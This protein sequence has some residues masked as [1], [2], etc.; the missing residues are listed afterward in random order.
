[1]KIKNISKIDL[2]EPIPVYDVI[3][4]YPYNN[5][6]IKCNNGY[7]VSHNC[8]MLDEVSF[9]EGANV[10]MEKSKIMQT[11]NGVHERMA[12]RFMVNGKIAGKMFILSSKKSEY[13][14]LESYIRKQQGKPGVKVC[15]ARLW[16]VK[17]QGTYT[18]EKFLVAIGGAATASK[19]ISDEETEYEFTLDDGTTKMYKYNDVVKLINGE[20][21]K[22]QN[23][24]SG[25]SI[26]L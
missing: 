13:D 26:I 24:K 5:F 3:N 19:I 7:I 16:D 17:P 4:A 15:D 1:M 21:E 12:S 18:G 23:I 14:F 9:K 20:E 11:Y 25:D 6:L 8:A 2:N 10:V 22:V